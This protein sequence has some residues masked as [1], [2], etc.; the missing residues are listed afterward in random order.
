[1]GQLINSMLQE[2]G[3]FY[4]PYTGTEPGLM[5]PDCM[6]Y[7]RAARNQDTHHLQPQN[8]GMELN[9]QSSLAMLVMSLKGL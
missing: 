7:H 8:K 6:L 3:R 9:A 1:M 2:D 5:Q 4:S